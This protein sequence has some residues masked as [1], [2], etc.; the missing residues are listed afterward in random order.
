M[1]FYVKAGY[2]WT[3]PLNNKK[4]KNI[5][6]AW[7]ELEFRKLFDFTDLTKVSF[8]TH[9]YDNLIDF[10]KLNNIEKISFVRGLFS[11][12]AII[13]LGPKVY[14]ALLDCLLKKSDGI[15][16]EQLELLQTKMTNENIILYRDNLSIH[17]KLI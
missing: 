1:Y 6:L 13:R 8:W 3:F 2:A 17:T 12:W 11:R 7:T 4:G 5:K 15:F 10:A 9:D 16:N 14:I